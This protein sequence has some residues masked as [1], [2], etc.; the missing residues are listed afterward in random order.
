MINQFRVGLGLD[1]GSSLDIRGIRVKNRVGKVN[2]AWPSFVGRRN[3]YQP[4]G[5]DALRLGSK[6]RSG[7]CVGGST[8]NCVNPLL[9]TSYI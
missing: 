2:S 3:K 7:S 6:G 5:G 4:K 1:L 8:Y 9:Q